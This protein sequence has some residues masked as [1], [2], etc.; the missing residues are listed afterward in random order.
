MKHADTPTMAKTFE[1]F[2]G[3]QANKGGEQ[4]GVNGDKEHL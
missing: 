1:N 2:E 4:S 3:Q